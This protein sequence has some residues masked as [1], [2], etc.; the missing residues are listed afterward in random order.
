[1]GVSSCATTTGTRRPSVGE[2][3]PGVRTAAT[4]LPVQGVGPAWLGP[5]AAV[6]HPQLT[7]LMRSAVEAA[8]SANR[9]EDI[10][11]ALIHWN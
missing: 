10:L 2:P 8:T 5:D 9:A 11:S 3:F 1:M 7:Q 4:A 6:S